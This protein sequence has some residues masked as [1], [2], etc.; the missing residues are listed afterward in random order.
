MKDYDDYDYNDTPRATAIGLNT[1]MNQASAMISTIT[2][3]ATI[4]ITGITTHMIM[5]NGMTENTTMS[6]MPATVIT[7][8]MTTPAT[9][10]QPD[11]LPVPAQ[12]HNGRQNRHPANTAQP[13]D[14]PNYVN[15]QT[16]RNTTH[17]HHA[18]TMHPQWKKPPTSVG[19]IRC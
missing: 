19:A 17:P 2:T 7:P 16:M 5:T 6:T 14:P 15:S 10:N 18:P 3:A 13:N 1:D 4:T 11:P 8:I 12:R 9:H